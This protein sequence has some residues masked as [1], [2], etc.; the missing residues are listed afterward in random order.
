MEEA[1]KKPMS[2]DDLDLNKR[3]TYADYLQW[4]FDE[5]V[6]L[7][8]GKIYR[9]SPAPG[10]NHQKISMSL[11]RLIS[12]FLLGKKCEVFAAPF[13]V[14][15]PLPPDRRNENQ[16]DT[17]VQPDLCV[18]CDS[19]K[20]DDK[21]CLGAPDW[22]IEILSKSTARKDLKEKFELYEFAGVKEYWVVHPQ[23]GTL[24]IYRLKDGKYE[25]FQKPFTGGDVVDSVVFP[26]LNMNVEEIFE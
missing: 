8:R 17:V 23:E 13:D 9:M 3:Y 16:M 18:I 15:L 22:I 19:S 25:G 6:E 12:S 26:D 10:R 24:L 5:T 11:S 20:L 7:I 1:K 14:R 4:T 2:V 21:G